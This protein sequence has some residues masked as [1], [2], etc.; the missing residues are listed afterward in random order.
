MSEYHYL[1]AAACVSVLAALHR[2]GRWREAE[3]ALVC[4]LPVSRFQTLAETLYW[5]PDESMA[6]STPILGSLQQTSLRYVEPLVAV[7][8]SAGA[9]PL[10]C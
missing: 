7:P 10:M 1:S 2:E 6:S 9:A 5:P 4:A 8:T 3:A